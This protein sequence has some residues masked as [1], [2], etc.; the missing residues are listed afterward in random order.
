MHALG[1]PR[2]GS[3]RNNMPAFLD[4][5]NLQPYIRDELRKKLTPV[6]FVDGRTIKQGYESDILPLICNVYLEARQAGVLTT[7]QLEVAQKF[8]TLL[9][10]FARVGIRALIYEQ[11]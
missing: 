10:A 4:S 6:E 5:K 11:L 3:S 1:R 8:E 9:M 2:K 7:N